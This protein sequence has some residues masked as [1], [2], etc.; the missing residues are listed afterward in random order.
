VN[1]GIWRGRLRR[2]PWRKVLRS[3]SERF[4]SSADEDTHEA[5][6]GHLR[7]ELRRSVL[8]EEA[9]GVLTAQHVI[10]VRVVAQ[11]KASEDEVTVEVRLVDV[12]NGSESVSCRVAPE[13]ELRVVSEPVE[14]FDAGYFTLRVLPP[15]L[16]ATSWRKSTV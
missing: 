3:L 10:D 14:R 5:P 4:L 16:G 15:A 12:R 1:K 13:K 9:H 11:M 2:G 6:R 8:V 7:I